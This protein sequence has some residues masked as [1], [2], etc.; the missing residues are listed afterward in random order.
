MNKTE[1]IFILIWKTKGKN[2]N[3]LMFGFC[4][5]TLR[6]F[7]ITRTVRSS[8]YIDLCGLNC[9]L[10]CVDCCIFNYFV[11]LLCVKS[12]TVLFV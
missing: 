3:Y 9:K 8:V 10:V 2:G 12:N 11:G 4:T 1:H 6:S 5:A 7:L